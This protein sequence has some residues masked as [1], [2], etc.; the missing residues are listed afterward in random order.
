MPVFTS[1]PFPSASFCFPSQDRQSWSEEGLSMRLARL[2]ATRAGICSCSALLLSMGDGAAIW[3]GGSSAYVRMMCSA[4]AQLRPMASKGGETESHGSSSPATYLSY[5]S[6][7]LRSIGKSQGNTGRS[8]RRALG[9]LNKLEREAPDWLLIGEGPSLV[10]PLHYAQLVVAVSAVRSLLPRRGFSG[11]SSV[12]GDQGEDWTGSSP[13]CSPTFNDMLALCVSVA[14]KE[15]LP[16]S[17]LLPL[18]SAVALEALCRQATSPEV[19]PRLSTAE[20]CEVLRLVTLAT[21]RCKATP[22]PLA[23]LYSYLSS[24][25]PLKP[26]EVLQ[27]LSALSRLQA[28]NTLDVARSVSRRGLGHPEKYTSQDLVFALLA[29]AFVDGVDVTY[30]SE[31]LSRCCIMVPAFS[32]EILGDASKY[33]ARLHPQRAGKVVARSCEREVRRVAYAIA[34]RAKELLG[35]FTVRDARYVLRCLTEHQVRH[36]ITNSKPIVSSSSMRVKILCTTVLL[37]SLYRKI[38]ARD[39]KLMSDA[40]GLGSRISDI[41]I[42]EALESIDKEAEEAGAEDLRQPKVDPLLTH[43]S[44]KYTQQRHKQLNELKKKVEHEH[45]DLADKFNELNPSLE[46]LS[47]YSILLMNELETLCSKNGLERGVELV[48]EIRAATNNEIRQAVSSIENG[49]NS[50]FQVLQRQ[51]AYKLDQEQKNPRMGEK[52]TSSEEVGPKMRD[53]KLMREC[54]DEWKAN[55]KNQVVDEIQYQSGITRSPRPSKPIDKKQFSVKESF[56]AVP[57]FFAESL[58]ALLMCEVVRIYLY[59]ENQ[60]LHCCASYPYRAMQGDPMHATYTEIMLA[61]D[62]HSTVCN[63]RIAVN[64]SESVYTLL[65]KRDL[66]VVKAELQASGWGSMRSCLIF[67]IIPHIGSTKSLGMIHAVNKVSPSPQDPGKF[68]SDDEVLVSMAARVLGCIL[69]RYPVAHFSLRVGEL[70]RKAV[71]PHEKITVI[72]DHIPERVTDLVT[73]AAEAGN[74]AVAKPAPIMIFRAPLCDVYVSK[75][76]RSRARKMGKLVVQDSTLSS[77][78]FNIS[79]VNELWQTGMEENV[80]M[81]QE[82]RKLED[83]MKHTNLLLRNI[84]D[85]LAAARTMQNI[86]EMSQYLQTLELFGR[87]ESVE[88]LSEF[89]SDTLIGKTQSGKTQKNVLP[90]LSGR[91]SSGGGQRTDVSGRIQGSAASIT[92]EESKIGQPSEG[93]T[94]PTE[95]LFLTE[96]ETKQLIHEHKLLNLAVASR[97]HTDGPDCIRCYSCDPEKK[98]AQVR[99]I[100]NRIKEGEAAKQR[101]E[102]R[103][104]NGPAYLRST[105]SIRA[106]EVENPV[107]SARH[108]NVQ[109]KPIAD[110]CTHLSEETGAGGR[111]TFRYNDNSLLFSLISKFVMTFSNVHMTSLAAPPPTR[112]MTDVWRWGGLINQGSTCYLNCVIQALFHT[113]IFR[114]KIFEIKSSDNLVLALQSVFCRLQKGDQNISTTDLTTAFGWVGDEVSVQHDVHELIQLLFDRLEKVLKGTPLENFIRDIFCGELIYRSQAVDTAVTYVSDRLETFYDLEV[115]V[116]DSESLH[117]SLQKLSTPEKIEGVEVDVKPG[118]SMKLNIERSLRLLHLPPV[119]M[120]HPNRVTFDTETYELRTINNRWEFA[121]NLDLTKFLINP[122]ELKLDKESLEKPP[123]KCKVKNQQYTL[124]AILIHC[125]TTRMGHYYAFIRLQGQWVSFSDEHVSP[126]TE[127]IVM[128]AAFGGQVTKNSPYDNERASVLIY[129][130]DSLADEILNDKDIVVP[131]N[132]FALKKCTVKFSVC[133][134]Y[135]N[136]TAVIDSSPRQTSQLPP[137]YSLDDLYAAI[138][139]VLGRPANS[140]QLVL[141]DS[142]IHKPLINIEKFKTE[143]RRYRLVVAPRFVFGI[144]RMYNQLP[145]YELLLSR[146][147]FMNFIQNHCEGKKDKVMYLVDN[148][149]RFRRAVPTDSREMRDVLLFRSDE[150]AAHF[151]EDPS[152]FCGPPCHHMTMEVVYLPSCCNGMR[153]T[154]RERMLVDGFSYGAIQRRV[155]D[156]FH[157]GRLADQIA[158]FGPEEMSIA[159]PNLPDYRSASESFGTCCLDGGRSKVLY[160]TILPESVE[161]LSLRYCIIFNGGWKSQPRIYLRKGTSTISLQKVLETAMSQIPSQLPDNFKKRFENSHNGQI[162]RLLRIGDGSQT[163]ELEGEERPKDTYLYVVDPCPPLTEGF[164]SYPVCFWSSQSQIKFFGIPTFILIKSSLDETGKAV[165]D[166]LWKRLRIPEDK[167]NPKLDMSRWMVYVETSKRKAKVG[168]KEK[169]KDIVGDGK[170]LRILVDR[171][172]MQELDGTVPPTKDSESL[173]ITDGVPHFNG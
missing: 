125:G 43:L 49:Y 25:G 4:A 53:E 17:E 20:L 87:S 162:A 119:L 83:T 50:A 78:E 136:G 130:N 22:P 106:K 79:S 158:F 160:Y 2:V 73:D 62:L 171:P 170:L 128:K 141:M 69:T 39:Y 134:L 48:K 15:H 3:Q 88:M 67:P 132:I 68:T 148:S 63:Q 89:I 45:A 101:M 91:R 90:V 55:V 46:L 40:S 11:R 150:D 153:E 137:D 105:S 58:A 93:F 56:S 126:T 76:H 143:N 94:E 74:R 145:N 124:H 60:N 102:S 21:K 135:D 9:V 1:I 103:Q 139:A 52:N 165:L 100:E 95:G 127:S 163:A 109:H 34:D 104:N 82:Y 27:V 16:V 120:V 32:S 41:S 70:F 131:D 173:I 31:V 115:I 86:A 65:T 112:E 80:I 38:A 6:R 61:K 164:E 71:Y 156:L 85:G 57:A 5:H 110:L 36:S 28:P 54:P 142:F 18:L 138:S 24:C 133:G 166:R 116:K 107:R 114:R 51:A 98:R 30:A 96:E 151:K 8:R 140:F 75:H 72:D 111:F 7:L 159:F 121:S 117:E 161:R 97:I 26:R 123:F 152:H 12:P 64:G 59:D 23:V 84:L 108:R 157:D 42:S 155:S 169:L 10:D 154:Q 168:V 92:V 13:Y 149:L 122:N 146:S 77:V 66:R 172:M 33:V 147:G 29:L 44:D 47:D 19:V 129:I 113:P 81:H 35:K 99:F 37:G 118:K 14:A 167:T 144:I